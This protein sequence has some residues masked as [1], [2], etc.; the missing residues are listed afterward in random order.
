MDGMD[1]DRPLGAPS[2]SQPS[3]SG[4]GLRISQP[5]SQPSTS[6]GAHHSS[7]Q[8]SEP[9]TP[10]G[11]PNM[12][13]QQQRRTSRGGGASPAWF[14]PRSRVTYSDRFIPVRASA[15]R[16]DFSVLD[17]EIAAAEVNK[18]ASEREVCV[19][20]MSAACWCSEWACRRRRVVACNCGWVSRA[21][22]LA[23]VAGACM[24]AGVL[25]VYLIAPCGPTP[26][27]D[28]N[29]AYN[30]LLRSELLGCQY[31]APISPDKAAQL[32]QLKGSCSPGGWAAH[33]A[34]LPFASLYPA[35]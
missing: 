4:T 18:S 30:M 10:V 19:S 8:S 11:S 22:G 21:S 31:P 16:L 3:S 32:E 13:Q 23:H 28:L 24:L 35:A 15:A 1:V 26:L 12:Q 14:S 34:L 7:Y 25:N 33:W 29:P 9:G 6:Y 2:G 17:R 20:I 27:Q 5:G